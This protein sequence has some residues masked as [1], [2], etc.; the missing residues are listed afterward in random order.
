MENLETVSSS[1]VTTL[2]GIATGLRSF[3]PLALI[4]W[5][6]RSG[7]LPVEGT[8]A[9]WVGRPAAVGLLT[10][11]AVGECIADKLPNAPDRTLPVAVVGRL[12]LSG[13][14][15]AIVATV[16]RRPV[17]GGVA[18]GVLGALGGTYG[19][20]SARTKLSK[21]LGADLVVAVTEDALAVGLAANSI[22]RVTQ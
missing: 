20:F 13:L 8:W 10:A 7:R 21:A 3:T 22:R 12:V 6:A 19:G 16:L 9:S 1:S 5:S 2:L 14:S 18:L 17:A 15:G 11:A 4:A